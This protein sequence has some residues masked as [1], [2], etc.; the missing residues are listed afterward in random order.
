MSSPDQ[1][2]EFVLL[3][4]LT[5]NI[6]SHLGNGSYHP[7][8]NPASST[9][10][11]AVPVASAEA[12]SL[13]ISTINQLIFDATHDSDHTIRSF[14]PAARPGRHRP[15]PLL[16]MRATT[17]RPGRR[18]ANPPIQADSGDVPILP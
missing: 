1:P 13:L 2:T 16:G 3:L 14:S 4:Q 11:Y 5:G 15:N 6:H 8:A 18:E 9:Q 17:A 7:V 12:A 10:N